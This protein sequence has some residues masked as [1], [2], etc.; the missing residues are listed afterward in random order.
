MFEF[1]YKGICMLSHFVVQAETTA[2]KN[3]TPAIFAR[4]KAVEFAWSGTG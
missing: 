1:W 2:H 4:V 3:N